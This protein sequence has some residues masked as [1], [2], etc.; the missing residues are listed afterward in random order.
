MLQNSMKK[1][2][3]FTSTLS[4]GGAEKQLL[5]FYQ[6]LR[7]DNDCYY[8]IAKGQSQNNI[9]S[10]ET[11]KTFFSFFYLIRE[12]LRVRPD[13]LITTLPT[14]NFINA[15]IKKFRILN[16]QSVVRIANYNIDLKTTKYVIKNS[17]KVIFN[18]IENLNLYSENFPDSDDKFF[19]VNNA[20]D[21]KYLSMQEKR[22]STDNVNALVVSRLTYNKGLDIL[23]NSMNE[24]MNEN[25]YVDIYGVGPELDKL[26]TQ[27]KNNKVNFIN[28][29]QD[30][31][32]CWKQY[33]LYIL[34][35]RKEGMSNALLEAQF[36]NIFSVVSDCKTGNK[37][38][39][40]L[41][42]NGILFESENYIDLKNKLLNFVNKKYRDEK[43]S[44]LIETN[45]SSENLKS[46]LQTALGI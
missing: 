46:S 12:L 7:K 23:I 29:F 2:V 38:I 43:S 30:L 26:R 18:S 13:I 42:N 40:N 22:V 11:N 9:K 3:F 39:I 1:I 45:F 17:D 28:K 16:F 10:F 6:I 37:E 14:P 4:G 21:Y 15:I 8:Y 27:S 33:N 32:H 31:Q 5:K 34:P 36:H 20:I 24:L 44:S 19:Y 25:L 35:S 41:T